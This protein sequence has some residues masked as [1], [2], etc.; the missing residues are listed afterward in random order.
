MILRAWVWD[1][2]AGV[3]RDQAGEPIIEIDPDVRSDLTE[4][5]ILALGEWIAEQGPAAIAARRPAAAGG[6]GR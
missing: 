1:Q 4:Q 5:E 2:H 6:T 3:V